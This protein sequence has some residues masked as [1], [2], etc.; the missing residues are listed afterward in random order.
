MFGFETDIAKR[1]VIAV[2]GEYPDLGVQG[3]MMRK[4]GQEVITHF[5][6]VAKN[7]F[8]GTGAIAGA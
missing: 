5:G 2:L 1:S 4:Y 6:G 7:V 8:T 3:V